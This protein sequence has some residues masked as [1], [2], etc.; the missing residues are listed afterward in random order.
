M[1]TGRMKSVTTV[2]PRPST[3][4]KRFERSLTP[5][6]LE[7]SAETTLSRVPR[8]D[9][10]TT[11]RAGEWWEYKLA[12][13]FAAFYATALLLEVSVAAL[14]LTALIVLMA[15][16]P[17]AAYVSI[18]ND[19]TDR[20]EDLAAGKQNR[21]I[22]RSRAYVAALVGITTGAGIVFSLLWRSDTLL[23]SAYLAAWLA[24]SLYSLP[25]FRFKA[26]GLAG[27]LC[28][29][30]GAHLFPTLVAVLL[31]FRAVDRPPDPVWLAAV[32]VWSF[33]NGLRGILW[34]QLTD[35]DNDHISGVRTFAQRHPPAAA[36]RLGTFLIFPLELAALGVLL[37]RMQ[38]HWPLA[39]LAAYA[40][41]TAIRAHRFALRLVIVKPKSRYLILLHEY[42]DLYLPVAVLLASA[43]HHPLDWLMLLLHLAVF[44]GR[45]RQT[46]RD[47][48]QLWSERRRPR[49]VPAG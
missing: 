3:R 49:H 29:A 45:L 30:S 40:A 26:R 33:A 17:G 48:L 46:L 37:W 7:Y 47:A 34:H 24:F 39:L 14:W 16:V 20:D 25:P 21:L 15:L 27:V 38:S 43:L 9:L 44:P 4:E 28:D 13:I 41:F 11:V 8:N 1:G 10:T 2:L 42:Y 23:L 19:A 35:R 5:L 22:G 31:V 18:I 12:P 6:A 36:I 32:G